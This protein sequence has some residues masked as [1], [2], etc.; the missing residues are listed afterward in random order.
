MGRMFL[1]GTLNIIFRWFG[2]NRTRL[3]DIRFIISTVNISVTQPTTDVGFWTWILS[4][5]FHG[6]FDFL[7]K[8]S[9][10]FYFFVNGMGLGKIFGDRLP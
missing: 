10:L 8:V 9:R 7:V 6:M 3:L 4:R 1:P 2:V 5:S